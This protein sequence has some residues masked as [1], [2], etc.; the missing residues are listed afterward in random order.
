MNAVEISA[1]VPVFNEEGCLLEL[2]RRL[3]AALAQISPSYEII[4]VNDGS[5]DRTAEV[6]RE[7]CA[8]NPHIRALHFTRNFGHHL[9]VTAGLDHASGRAVV[10]MDGDLQD[11]PE[12]IPKLFDKY[13]EGFKVVYAVRQNKKFSLFKRLTASAFLTILN[14]ISDVNFELNSTIFRIL[15]RQVVRELRNC[16]ERS[17]YVIGLIDW[18][19]F[20]S[21]AVPVEHGYRYAGVTKY[22]FRKLVRLANNAFLGFSTAPL[23]LSIYVGIFVAMVGF[24]YGAVIAFRALTE[25]ISV[26]GWAS[27][28]VSILVMSGMLMVFLGVIGFYIN[29]IYLQLLARPLYVVDEASNFHAPP[30]AASMNS[31]SAVMAH[32]DDPDSPTEAASR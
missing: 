16:R 24:A 21:A 8:T 32:S 14:R 6:L 10:V 20:K 19:G 5:R 26:E 30:P 12:E 18:L 17:R 2:W 4:F 11:L 25:S 13:R 22:S 29:N 7:L 15:D 31:G 27:V 3:S 28:I 9:A 1:V 23:K